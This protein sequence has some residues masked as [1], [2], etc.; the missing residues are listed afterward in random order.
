MEWKKASYGG[1]VSKSG[2]GKL[3]AVTKGG[4]PKGG[5]WPAKASV[6]KA[7]IV[8]GMT[9]GNKGVPPMGGSRS[10]KKAPRD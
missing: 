7:G 8:S 9:Q 6:A 4:L 10:N 5:N 2:G 3:D 1:T